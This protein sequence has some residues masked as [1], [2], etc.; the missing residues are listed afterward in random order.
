MITVTRIVTPTGEYIDVE[1][2]VA[3]LTVAQAVDLKVKLDLALAESVKAHEEL[4]AR[5]GGKL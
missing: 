2:Y 5:K 3:R 4:E 1:L